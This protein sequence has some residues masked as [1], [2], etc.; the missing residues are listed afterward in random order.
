MS[1]TSR[2]ICF[3]V[4]GRKFRCCR[5]LKLASGELRLTSI[6]IEAQAHLVFERERGLSC[7]LI[8]DSMIPTQKIIQLS[9]DVD[10]LEQAFLPSTSLAPARSP[11]RLYQ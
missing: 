6:Q 9:D 7:F 2:Y 4:C 11:S 1:W 5:A 8:F 10:A 3:M